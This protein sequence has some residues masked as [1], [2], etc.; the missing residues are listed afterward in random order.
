MAGEVGAAGSGAAVQEAG[1]KTGDKTA[2]KTSKMM[3]ESKTQKAS[4]SKDIENIYDTGRPG[5]ACSRRRPAFRS[6]N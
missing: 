3:N 5:G 2:S 1:N 4:N 6:M